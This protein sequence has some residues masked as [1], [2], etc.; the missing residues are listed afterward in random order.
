MHPYPTPTRLQR[1]TFLAIALAISLLTLG[2]V[3][4][5]AEHY[6]G[7]T[8]AAQRIALVAPAARVH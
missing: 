8:S 1:A 2:W 7:A 6:A 5:L 3:G 4:G